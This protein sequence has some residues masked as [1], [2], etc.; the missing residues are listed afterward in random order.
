VWTLVLIV[1]MSLNSVGV[2]TLPGFTSK[3]AC[4]AAAE[5]AKDA[6]T[7]LVTVR[8]FCLEVK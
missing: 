1:S 3:A 7:N 5:Q 4:T 2:T 6:P 8:V